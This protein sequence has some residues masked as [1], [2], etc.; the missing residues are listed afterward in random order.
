MIA[1]GQRRCFI[2]SLVLKKYDSSLGLKMTEVAK[3]AEIAKVAE[4]PNLDRVLPQELLA[5]GAFV[6]CVKQSTALQP[7]T[8]LSPKAIG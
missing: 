3:M 1:N 7:Q 5:Q 2:I 8:W 6:C 4:W